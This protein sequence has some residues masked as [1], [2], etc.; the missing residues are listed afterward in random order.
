MAG[1]P[2]LGSEPAL[3]AVAS[4]IANYSARILY[5]HDPELGPAD[6]NSYFGEIEIL[7]GQWG[8]PRDIQVGPGFI[9]HNTAITYDTS[10]G[11]EGVCI[12]VILCRRVGC[13]N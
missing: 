1:L 5:R 8:L 2:K 9:P 3:L 7:Q 6:I 12:S 11:P 13:T 4:N 10:Y